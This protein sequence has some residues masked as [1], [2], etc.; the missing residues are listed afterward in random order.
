M[1]CS[2]SDVWFIL[3]ISPFR[4][5]DGV[6]LAVDAC[7]GVMLAT[8]R[9]IRQAVQEDLPICL[10]ITKVDRQDMLLTPALTLPS[11][12][13]LPSSLCSLRLIT[14]LKLPPADAYHKLRHTIEEVNGF[15]AKASAGS[16][17]RDR[18]VDPVKGNVTFSSALYG[19]SFTL[20]SFAQL[21]VDVWGVD[22]DPKEL[23]RRLWGD[24]YFN[25]VSQFNPPPHPP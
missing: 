1:T 9:V 3:F 23:A 2:P 5:A 15:I 16:P 14:E 25:P 12:P 11:K 24:L 13:H 22:M 17:S 4:L 6:L 19:W 7:E 8:E 10:L 18:E 21:Y 20:E